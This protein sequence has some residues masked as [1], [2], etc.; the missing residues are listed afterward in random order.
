MTAETKEAVASVGELLAYPM[1][2][3]FDDVRKLTP[4]LRTILT[5]LERAERERDEARYRPLGDNHHNA[6]SCP[7]C[8][9]DR[10]DPK[11]A[12][13][14]LAA[15]KAEVVGVVGALRDRLHAM[16]GAVFDITDV[17]ADV[18]ALKRA[19]DLLAKLTPTPP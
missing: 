3:T 5:A 14:A 8:N 10:I 6:L 12:E 18:D 1:A 4:R 19:D 11:A 9:P 2:L 7:Y 17:S 15:L 13:A 16:V